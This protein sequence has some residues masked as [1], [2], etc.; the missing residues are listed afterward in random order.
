M[1]LVDLFL[2]VLLILKAQMSEL[3][4]LED[5]MLVE[6]VLDFVCQ[7]ELDLELKEKLTE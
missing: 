4:L 5:L 3:R 7:P 1:V 2:V 6:V